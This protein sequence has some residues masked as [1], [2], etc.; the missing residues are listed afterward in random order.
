MIRCYEKSLRDLPT[1]TVQLQVSRWQRRLLVTE[2]K[3]V[4]ASQAMVYRTHEEFC[5]RGLVARDSNAIKEGGVDFLGV[6]ASHGVSGSCLS[7]V[8]SFPA[9]LA[10]VLRLLNSNRPAIATTTCLSLET[11]SN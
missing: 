5:T 11:E 6:I 2:Q 4:E 1:A 10:K 3:I 8:P 9:V 7:V